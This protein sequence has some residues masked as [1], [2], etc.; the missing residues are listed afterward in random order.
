MEAQQTSSRL[1]VFELSSPGDI[2]A[3]LRAWLKEVQSAIQREAGVVCYRVSAQFALDEQ[4]TNVLHLCLPEDR[5]ASA[6]ADAARRE[7]LRLGRISIAGPLP[8]NG[9]TGTL[10]TA[11]ALPLRKYSN[12]V[13]SWL[14]FEAAI[15]KQQQLTNIIETIGLSLGWV[16]Y[17]QGESLLLATE[18][19]DS[20]STQALKSIVSLA[21]SESFTEAA[22]AL[23]TDIADRFYCDRVSIGLIQNSIMRVEAI[24][25]TGKFSKKMALV[26]KLRKAMEEAF[27]QKEA[28]LWPNTDKFSEQFADAQADLAEKDMTRSVLT[29]PLFDGRNYA[30][31]IVF[32]RSNGS[33]FSKDDTET[34]ESISGI[35][36]PLLVEK[37]HNDRWLITRAGFSLI[38]FLKGTFGRRNFAIKL[39][40]TGIMVLLTLLTTI[41]RPRNI[42]ATAVVEGTENR[43]VSAA[44]DGF[45]AEV[46]AREGDQVSAGEPLF[47]LDDRDFALEKLRLLAL[48]SQAELELDR[49]ISA[50]DRAET[51]LVEA[52]LRQIDAQLALVDQQ[53]ERSIVEAP[54]D[55]IVISGDLTRSIGRAVS[56]G[57]NLMILSPADDYRVTMSVKEGDIR[58]IAPG[59]T[60][61]L[62]L[63]AIPERSFDVEV[64]ELIPVARYEGGGTLFAVEAKLK[65]STNLLLHGMSGSVRILVDDV[66]LIVLW[67][68]PL[69]DS[70]RLWIWRYIAI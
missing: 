33:H 53:I 47:R 2:E 30:G 56:R 10:G 51:T 67:G 20:R 15:P 28:L 19:K 9:H 37:R 58:L 69:W 54:F 8:G 64:T 44:F 63:G 60:G 62:R 11:V 55:A 68:K 66:P 27:D 32:E 42:V 25:H 12:G 29:I 61:R 23:A 13:M 43:A 46:T 6:E 4:A 39:I 5:I 24:S 18:N 3:R 22:R 59:Q 57:E 70:V 45:I 26:R 40:I 49:A 48:R 34:L 36:T 7:A 52:R 17:L 35:L 65:G 50:R 1:T 16:H 41:E 21:S 14:E 31:A 38:K